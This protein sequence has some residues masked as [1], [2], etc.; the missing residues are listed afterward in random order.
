MK[1]LRRLLCPPR[2]P[3]RTLAEARALLP[4]LGAVEIVIE[5]PPEPGW[6][7]ASV[8]DEAGLWHVW[9]DPTDPPDALLHELLHV[10]LGEVR[11]NPG[12]VEEQAVVDLCRA[13][14]R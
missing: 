10:L 9:V 2:T 6:G 1:C 4:C 14:L 11:L 13:L 8:R 3:P 7:S 12:A 5:E